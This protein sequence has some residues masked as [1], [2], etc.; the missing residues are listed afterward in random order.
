MDNSQHDKALTTEVVAATMLMTALSSNEIDDAS[1]GE[2]LWK[3][4]QCCASRNVHF[5]A[6]F[7]M[8]AYHC[9]KL[10]QKAWARP[11]S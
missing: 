6:D 8:I 9:L 4:L 10:C 2:E 7:Y 5:S 11:R 3:P 1:D